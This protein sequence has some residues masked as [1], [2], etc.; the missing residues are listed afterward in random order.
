MAGKESAISLPAILFL[1]DLYWNP[2]SLMQQIRSRAALYIPIVL[3]GGLVAW[4]ILGSLT[5]G[6]A[7]GFSSAGVSPALYAL[8]Q[9]RVIPEYIKLFLLP[10]GQNGDWAMPFFHS[11][12]DNGAW[13]WLLGMVVMAG[14]IVASNT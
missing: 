12:T 8:T 10:M 11:L 4:K 6:T 2:A 9:C 7:A 5:S 1:T 13:V 3:G 14:V